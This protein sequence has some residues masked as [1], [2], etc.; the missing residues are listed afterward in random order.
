MAADPF[1]VL[2]TAAVRD[3]RNGPTFVA[4]LQARMPGVPIRILSGE[5]EAEFSA[6]GVLCGIPQADGILADIGGGS[7]EL[8]RLDAGVRGEASQPCRSA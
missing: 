5:E 8:V 7:L 2:A 3:A 1:E 6:A 4:A